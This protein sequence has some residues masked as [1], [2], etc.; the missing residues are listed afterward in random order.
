MCG[1]VGYVGPRQAAEFL[2]PGLRRLEY[3][4]YDSSGIVTITP[5]K[6]MAVVKA[7]GRLDR[8]ASRLADTPL[9]GRIGLGHTRWATHGAATDENAHPHIGGNDVVAVVHNG[10]IENYLPLKEGLESQGY[11]FRSATDSEVIAH[12]VAH[13]FERLYEEGAPFDPAE[14]AARNYAP[15]VA[16]VTKALSKLRGTYGLGIVFRDYPEVLFAAR[17]GSPLVVGVGTGENFIASDASPLVGRTDKIVYLADHELA[18]LTA[19]GLRVI[20]RDQ[21]EVPHDVQVLDLAPGD[22]DRGGYEHFMLKEIFEQPETVQNT[23]RGRLSLDDATAHFGGL[24]LSAQQLR[25]VNRMLLTACGTSW[26]AALV[27][28]YLIE[29][30]ARLPVEVEYASELR[31]RNPPLDN[32]TLVFAITQSGETADTLG[33]LREMKRQGH[34]TLAIC[35]VVGST[36]AKE[37]N[38]GIYLHAG[39]EIGVASTKAFTSQCVALA[40]LALYFGRLRHLNYAQGMQMIEQLQ[41]L[42][43]LLRQALSADDD[44]RRIAAKYHQCNNFLYLGRQYNFPTALEGALK[45]KEISYIHAEGYPA[46]E[47]KH[48]PIALVDENTPS[49]FLIPNGPVY[50]KVMSNMEEIKARGGP[51]IAVTCESGTRA[52]EL[53]DDVILIPTTEEF[54]QPIVTAIPLQLLAYHIAVLRGC[55]VDKPRNLAKSVTVE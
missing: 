14:M 26:H 35:N 6:K 11:R 49:V 3:R 13:C 4:G 27:G 55:D 10:V 23:M 12:L 8:L 41:S 53:A 32:N 39:P 38:G 20:D 52:A 51:V 30:F 34:P 36:I 40:M 28:E 22:V 48:G 24:N 43:D 46:A 42:P 31:Y 33:A 19:D 45:L 1:I 15:L 9:V 21:G 17:L 44:V 2:L 16:A 54:L 37:A 47:M 18:V 29:Q 50:D 5:E 7:A 25:S